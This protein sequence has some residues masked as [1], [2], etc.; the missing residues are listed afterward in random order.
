MKQQHVGQS[1]VGV[2]L[3]AVMTAICGVV[4]AETMALYP[5]GDQ[6]PGTSAVGAA[7]ANQAKPGSYGG[8]VSASG[9]GV[10]MFSDVVPGRYAFEG[11]EHNAMLV[12]TNVRSLYMP[13]KNVS[14]AF[15]NLATDLVKSEAW[16]AEL[17]YM[18]PSGV[19][20]YT[21][22]SPQLMMLPVGVVNDYAGGKASSLGC[23]ITAAGKITC[24]ASTATGA[25]GYSYKDNVSGWL[26]NDGIWHHVAVQYANGQCR[27]IC[28]YNDA[29]SVCVWKTVEFATPQEGI[30]FVLGNGLFKGYISCPRFSNEVLPTSRLLR[31]TDEPTYFPETVV[32]WSFE[33]ASGANLTTQTNCY[34]RYPAYHRVLT[35]QFFWAGNTARKN[36]VL[37][38]TGQATTVSAN[39]QGQYPMYEKQ[40]RRHQVLSEGE[41]AI[42]RSEASMFLQIGK[43][44]DT[45]YNSSEVSV[46]STAIPYVNGDF[47]AEGYFRFDKEQWENDFTDKSR[48]RVSLMMQ[49]QAPTAYAWYLN[50]FPESKFLQFG[51]SLKG[52]VSPTAAFN[53]SAVDIADGAWHH[54]AA[55]YEHATGKVAVYV[56]FNQVVDAKIEQGQIM[57][58]TT[59][60]AGY[61]AFTVGKKANGHP[62]PGWVDEVRF[63]RT[64][65]PVSRFL[66][67][68]K[69][70]TGM[71][72]IFR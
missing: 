45:W 12:S 39:D 70:K 19:N 58:S 67:L 4:S 54:V 33:G 71:L 53:S 64:V 63:S 21:T 37:A 28:D 30:A 10:V 32:H 40:D 2:G 1:F 11:S 9:E 23:S 15:E 65:L 20:D 24:F 43:A 57:F 48:P 55:T 72:L 50:F 42:G 60:A 62:F 29:S 56:D 25:M 22:Y 35:N 3:S 47:T 52:G 61:N 26:L 49:T 7:L 34:S 16:T 6:V 27:V 31:A 14:I 68:S 59:A 46:D 17:F 44:V 69:E 66:R 38:M 36:L 51:M 5:F 18:V 13:D 8:T 41:L